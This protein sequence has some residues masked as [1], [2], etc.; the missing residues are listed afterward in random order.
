MPSEA[1]RVLEPLKDLLVQVQRPPLPNMNELVGLFLEALSTPRFE[2]VI[3]FVILEKVSPEVASDFRDGNL[4]GDV[5]CAVNQVQERGA[6]EGG[7]RTARKLELS[8]API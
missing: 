7:E 4:L 8:I 3:L 5:I 1:H 2:V 6:R